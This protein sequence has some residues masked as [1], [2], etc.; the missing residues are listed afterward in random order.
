[1]R[2]SP[3]SAIIAGYYAVM[4]VWTFALYAWDKHAAQRAGGRVRERTLHV[5][6][7]CGGFLGALAGQQWLRHKSLRS[8]FVVGA[9]GA[10]LLHA[11]G[12]AWWLARR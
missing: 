1:M 3:A 7:W 9:W 8:A 11:A 12:W 6:A 10:L 4:T 2:L 5:L